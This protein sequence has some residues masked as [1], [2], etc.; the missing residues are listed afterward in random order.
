MNAIDREAAGCAG[1]HPDATRRRD[2]RPPSAPAVAA[3]GGTG[4]GYRHW[5]H[6]LLVVH[7]GPLHREHRQC[8][9]PGRHRRSWT[10]HRGRRGGHQGGRQP[11]RPCRRSA[12]RAGSRPTG[13]PVSP[14][15]PPPPPRRLPRSR[16]RSGRSPS[17]R[18]RSMRRRRLSPRRRRSRRGQAPMRRDPARWCPAAGRLASPT[19]RRSPMHARPTPQ[20]FRRRP[21]RQPRSSSLPCFRPR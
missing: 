9:R 14:R 4:G 6:R 18:R 21:R 8:L 10:A 5:R 2:P 11:A 7:R 20:W 13:G 16:R 17:S 15:P 19:T 1:G 12:D 3:G